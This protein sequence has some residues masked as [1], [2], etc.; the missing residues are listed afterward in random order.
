MQKHW[1]EQRE[2]LGPQETRAA[3]RQN[4]AENANVCRSNSQVSTRAA[5]ETMHEN[6]GCI[7]RKGADD[8]SSVDGKLSEDIRINAKGK[9]KMED[10]SDHEINYK[11]DKRQTEKEI[12]MRKHRK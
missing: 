1:E 7:I 11:H 12:K 4:R 10:S 8:T 5:D 9:Q 3:W 2:T 6:K